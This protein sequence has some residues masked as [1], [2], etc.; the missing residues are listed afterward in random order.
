MLLRNS[1]STKFSNQSFDKKRLWLGMIVGLFTAFVFYCF[2]SLVFIS[3]DFSIYYEWTGYALVAPTEIKYYHFLFAFIGLIMGQLAFLEFFVN[4]NRRFMMQRYEKFNAFTNV[5]FSIWSTFFFGFSWS[6]YTGLL[7]FGSLLTIYKFQGIG[8]WA[9][10]LTIIWLQLYVGSQFQKI[11]GF[12]LRT[13]L[14]GIIGICFLAFLFSQ[15]HLVTIKEAYH[16]RVRN[17]PHYKLKI[18]LPVVPNENA[19]TKL[20]HKS[21]ITSIFV[22]DPEKDDIPNFST[23]EGNEFSIHK[24]D[25]FL[26]NFRVMIPEKKRRAIIAHLFIDKDL[27]MKHVNKLFETLSINSQHKISLA[28]LTEAENVPD[29]YYYTTDKGLSVRLPFV[30]FYNNYWGNY[31]RQNP[32]TSFKDFKSIFEGNNHEQLCIADFFEPIDNEIKV[33]ADGSISFQNELI[34]KDDLFKKIKSAI[35]DS[36]NEQNYIILNVDPNVNYGLYFFVRHE[37]KRALNE[38]RNESALINYGIEYS[39]LEREKKMEIREEHRFFLVDFISEEERFI[40]NFFKE[41]NNTK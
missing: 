31:L 33:E 28:A 15:V 30:C 24:M 8:W 16:L 3:L 4:K 32:S 13:K 5:R 34:A 37:Y 1:I 22:G 6:V 21:L 36:N 41:K 27:K 9:S 10:L 25:L 23:S 26:E 39:F 12:N 14:I 29:V 18:N 40:Y 35:A 2:L 19:T 17:L 20:T 7:S 11:F 38:I